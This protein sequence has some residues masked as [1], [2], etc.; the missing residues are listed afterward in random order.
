MRWAAGAGV[1]G[2]KFFNR[3]DETPAINPRGDRRGEEAWDG[4]RRPP[5]PARRRP[6]QRA[7]R[8]GAKRGLGTVTHFY[9]HFE[10]LLKQNPAPARARRL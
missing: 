8:C 4:H 1:D 7:G 10:A 5:F 6:V 3:G 9:G 2:I